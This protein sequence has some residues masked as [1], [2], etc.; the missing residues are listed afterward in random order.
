MEP[1]RDFDRLP[2]VIQGEFEQLSP[3]LQRIA[4]YAPPVVEIVSQAHIRKIPVLALTDSLVS[5]L[6]RNA[7]LYFAVPDPEAH[8]FRP[9]AA[10]IVLA[11]SLILALGYYRDARIGDSLGAS[12]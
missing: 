5:P 6:A 10:Q 1:I 11:Q 3:H 9:L 8:R 7:D 4:Q 12:E 2:E